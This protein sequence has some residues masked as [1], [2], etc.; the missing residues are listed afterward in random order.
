M[1]I[2]VLKY[3]GDVTVKTIN[4]FD[5]VDMMLITVISGDEELFISYKDDTAEV[6]D[7]GKATRFMD[8][9]DYVYVIY[10]A[11]KSKN[12]IDNPIF[13]DRT[14]SYWVDDVDDGIYDEAFMVM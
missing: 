6:V 9:V 8:Y 13:M 4:N 11:D 10:D 3:N 14:S 7:P 2:K 12:L 1:D 5:N